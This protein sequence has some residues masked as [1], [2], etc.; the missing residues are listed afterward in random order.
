[1][2][3]FLLLFGVAS[4]HVI[5]PVDNCTEHVNYV[6]PSENSLVLDPC[7]DGDCWTYCD[8][9]T[10]HEDAM[11]DTEF[12][13]DHLESEQKICIQ[14]GCADFHYAHIRQ[15]HILERCAIDKCHVHENEVERVRPCSQLLIGASV[16]YETV[17]NIKLRFDRQNTLNRSLVEFSKHRF[18]HD[19]NTILSAQHDV[20]WDLELSA[21]DMTKIL[22]VKEPLREMAMLEAMRGALS[23]TIIRSKNISTY[24]QEVSDHVFGMDNQ[25]WLILG[26]TK[27]LVTL[28]GA[29]EKLKEYMDMIRDMV[30]HQY[31]YGP[32]E[33]PPISFLVSEIERECVLCEH[34]Q[35]KFDGQHFSCDCNPGWQGM[36]CGD[37]KKSC[38]DEPCLVGGRCVNEYGTYRCEC[39]SEKT[40]HWCHI[41]VNETLG[42]NAT[43]EAH[44]CQHG[45]ICLSTSEG[46]VC[47]CPLAFSTSKGRNCQYALTDCLDQN[48]C[49]NGDCVFDG[50]RISCDCPKEPMYKQPFWSGDAC[51]FDQFECDYDR[52]MYHHQV[53]LHA[54]PCSGHGVCTLDRENNGW[55][56]FCESDY[57]GDRCSVSVDETDLCL[58]YH[59]ACIHGTCDHCADADSCT[60]SCEPGYE[61]EQCSFEIDEC[62]TNP[63]KNGAECI[64]HIN[65]FYC[66][67]STI[68]GQYG[69]ELC[70]EQVTC[71]QKPCG[72]YFISCN[73]ESSELS[74]I[75]C[76]CLPGWSGERC[77][78]DARV[79]SDNLCLNGGNCALGHSGAFC[80]CPEGWTGDRCQHPPTY[81]D[82]QPCGTY[83]TCSI[84]G[85]GYKCTCEPGW[86]GEQCNHNIDDCLAKPCKHGACVD[87]INDYACLCESGW[88]G[89][90]CD[91]LKTPCDHVT[92]SNN[93]ICVDTRLVVTKADFEC[94]CAARTC[95]ATLSATLSPTRPTRPTHPTH[96]FWALLG[97]I[98]VTSVL[99][100]GY[101]CVQSTPRRK[102]SSFTPL[103]QLIPLQ[104]TTKLNI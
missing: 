33:C 50:A 85:D 5:W 58:L 61:G 38:A 55:E 11:N 91:I 25:L 21:T 42:C 46:Y 65:G 29:M 30:V 15:T 14:T 57:L 9:L 98:C 95:R 45:S 66:D 23:S 87:K 18:I 88:R 102:R 76:I 16:M 49:D 90:N 12:S 51:S 59:T 56:C 22:E 32:D 4:G 99:C 47:E 94:L 101:H 60:C 62:D 13:E 78:I 53:M 41:D 20:L 69:G 28:S 104:P 82:S 8:H 81:C 1:M 10:W 24:I 39:P 67:C 40:G 48:P 72:D 93:G 31:V 64:D 71:A 79:C 19:V 75:N 84:M 68:V 97:V 70:T 6:V 2:L 54:H 43:G 35:C 80:I 89:R 103:S 34:G 17:Y 86:D 7:S 3:F 92:C 96:W 74:G 26:Q 52:N 77:E 44:P 37:A 63:C 100:A 36:W 83:G 27:M 73:D